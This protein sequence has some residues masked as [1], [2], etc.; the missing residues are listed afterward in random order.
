MPTSDPDP[1]QPRAMTTGRRRAQPSRDGG[2]TTIIAMRSRQQSI[3]S[4]GL[5]PFTCACHA[6]TSCVLHVGSAQTSAHQSLPQAASPSPARFIGFNARN[7][8]CDL[9]GWQPEINWYI[10]YRVTR[11]RIA[12][13]LL[14]AGRRQLQSVRTGAGRFRGC[15]ASTA[16]LAP[17]ARALIGMHAYA[18]SMLM[19]AD[20]THVT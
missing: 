18:R 1:E 20:D 6:V 7:L 10:Q 14:S 12:N 11:E 15:A 16:A 9:A 19:S 3:V 5:V 2:C 13:L 4:H 17:C 8:E